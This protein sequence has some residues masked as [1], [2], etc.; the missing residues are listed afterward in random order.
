MPTD[1]LSCAGCLAVKAAW[2]RV[3][4]AIAAVEAADAE[5]AKAKLKVDL[6]VKERDAAKN[7]WHEARAR[8]QD[9]EW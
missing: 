4:E 7:A 9:D 1:S 3:K 8:L 2:S 5:V 6:A